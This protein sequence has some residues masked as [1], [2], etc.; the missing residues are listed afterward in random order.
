MPAAGGCHA[1]RRL[2]AHDI[3]P[4]A[5]RDPGGQVLHL[6]GCTHLVAQLHR[7][8]AP[9]SV[10]QHLHRLRPVRLV[11]REFDARGVGLGGVEHLERVRLAHK[12]LRAQRVPQHCQAEP[13]I[14]LFRKATVWAKAKTMYVPAS[15]QH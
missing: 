11:D 15:M 7:H 1:A 9:L 5:H 10:H 13:W 2:D 14:G 6:A 3:V 12:E 8:I 4:R